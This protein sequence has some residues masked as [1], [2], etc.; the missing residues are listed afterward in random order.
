[1][2]HTYFITDA[3]CAGSVQISSCFVWY[4]IRCRIG[5]L[6]GFCFVSLWAIYIASFTSFLLVSFTI[7]KIFFGFLEVGDFISVC[8]LPNFR[9][10]R[11]TL[12]Y[13]DNTVLRVFS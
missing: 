2:S 1:M 3:S 7:I 9:K 10:G 6:S 8:V 11:P 12:K 13:S 4:F 5:R